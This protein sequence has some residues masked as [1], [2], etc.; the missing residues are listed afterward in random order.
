MVTEHRRPSPPTENPPI[1]PLY[2]TM[3]TNLPHQIM[4]YKS[5]P[6]PPTTP[7]FP[8]AATVLDYIESYASHFQLISHIRFNTSVQDVRR[9]MEN[10]EWIVTLSTGEI[11]NFDV[12]CVGN[13]HF[14]V[15]RY[16]DVPG[17][18]TWLETGRALHSAWYRSPSAISGEVVLVAG[19]GPSGHDIASDMCASGKSVIHAVSGTVPID[20]ANL[21]IR[22]RVVEFL[23]DGSV[24]FEDGSMEFGIDQCI[25]ATGYKMAFP[26]LS[27]VMQ[28]T[29][30]PPYSPLP[31]GFY[32]SPY[33]LFPLAKHMF[34]LRAP[35]PSWSL[36][37]MGLTLRGIPFSLFEAQARAI[38]HAIRNPESLS[39]EAEAQKIISRHEKLRADY[40]DDDEA[41][42]KMWHKVT[43]AESFEYR[44]DL[45]EYSGSSERVEE[46][47]KAAWDKKIALRREWRQLEASCEAGSW[48]EN[49]GPGKNGQIKILQRLA[50]RAEQDLE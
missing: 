39:T 16:P 33:H 15:P 17:L 2:D 47:E 40:A 37:L 3:T 45:N 29:T 48:L 20:I 28:H 6:F 18:S 26:F 11:Q 50:E 31:E 46:W 12:I 13:G 43:E 49:V 7:I 41:V 9:S 14:R 19:G 27:S 30:S 22:G 42:A 21:R 4:S 38:V 35:F 34:P 36:A 25:L 23:P 24:A 8:A 1:T 32:A 5:F 44:D 10:A